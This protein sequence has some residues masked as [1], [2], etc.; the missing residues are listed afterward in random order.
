MTDVP[1]WWRS[2]RRHRD[3]PGAFGSRTK[4]DGIWRSMDSEIRIFMMYDWSDRLDE[5]F[6][7]LAE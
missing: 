4:S 2:C 3:I 5:L 7:C 1:T 6:F